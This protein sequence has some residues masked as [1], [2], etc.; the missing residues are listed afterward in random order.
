MYP[1]VINTVI[2]IATI[3]FLM[4]FFTSVNAQE[5]SISIEPSLTEIH[6]QP[7]STILQEFIISNTG[8]TQTFTTNV[9]PFRPT[10]NFGNIEMDTELSGPIRFEI[11]NKD[12]TINKPYIVTEDKGKEVVL[13]IRIPDNIEEGD[14]YYALHTTHETGRVIEGETSISHKLHVSGLILIHIAKGEL[15][16]QATIGD[17]DISNDRG[18]FKTNERIPFKL[19]VNNVGRNAFKTDGYLHIVGPGVDK[20]LPLLT[21]NV[22]SMSSRQL[23]LETG[24][25][26]EGFFVGKYTVTAVLDAGGNTLQAQTSF[27]VLPTTILFWLSIGGLIIGGAIYIIR[28]ESK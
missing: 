9:L 18:Y 17:Y 6:A 23:S 20:R 25:Y 4:P 5:A 12:I 22:L 3:L 26:F 2:G 15:D 8:D 24:A 16:Q 19:V 27:F 11:K 28:R 13:E 1:Q 7:G 10:D 14:Y 21:E